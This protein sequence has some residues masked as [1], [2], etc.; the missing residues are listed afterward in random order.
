MEI[1]NKIESIEKIKELNL[2]KFPEEL[3][4]ENEEEKVKQFIEKYPAKYYAIRDKSKAKG[5]FKLKVEKDKVL[6]N[7][8][9]YK[10]FT[11]NVSSINYNK[12]QLLVGE[13]EILSNNEVY[14]TLSTNPNYSVRDALC[15]PTYNLKTNIFDNRLNEVEYFDKIYDYISKNDLFDCIVEFALF[16]KKV[17]IN[18]EEIV[19][20][21]LRTNY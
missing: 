8:K 9:E 11:I 20:Y 17:G 4:K 16:N 3:F 5:I 1:N 10:L 7:I 6:D 21:E 12:N 2:N 18:K 19:I 14:L 15:N 13:I